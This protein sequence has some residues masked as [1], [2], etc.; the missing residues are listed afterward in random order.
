MKIRPVTAEFF[1]ADGQTGRHDK[2]N[3]SFFK[4]FRKRPNN[5]DNLP[6]YT[7]VGFAPSSLGRYRRQPLLVHP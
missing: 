5:N 6:R 7:E 1:Y 4:I 3:N 2:T